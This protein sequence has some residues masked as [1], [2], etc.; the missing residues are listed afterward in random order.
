MMYGVISVLLIF[1]YFTATSQGRAVILLLFIIFFVPFSISLSPVEIFHLRISFLQV[2]VNLWSSQAPWSKRKKV[3]RVGDVFGAPLAT[4]SWKNRFRRKLLD[5]FGIPGKMSLLVVDVKVFLENSIF[6]LTSQWWIMKGIHEEWLIRC[7]MG[8]YFQY[9]FHIRYVL[10]TLPWTSRPGPR[11]AP[12]FG[13]W[14]MT[15]SKSGKVVGST[16]VPLT[17]PG[18]WER[19]HM[20]LMSSCDLPWI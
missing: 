1:Q 7:L 16:V 6:I 15:L 10:E 20:T 4:W 13:S 12:F 8:V 5:F 18:N 2:R 9:H 11:K 17:S 14:E 19:S 3:G